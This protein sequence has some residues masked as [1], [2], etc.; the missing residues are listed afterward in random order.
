LFSNVLYTLLQVKPEIFVEYIFGALLLLY[1]ITLNA[2]K[3]VH[4]V[5]THFSENRNTVPA[6]S[7]KSLLLRLCF[8][9]FQNYMFKKHNN[10]T[11]DKT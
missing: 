3:L 11:L 9:S 1:L 6:H 8:F 2:F 4:F 7:S 5:P 10:I